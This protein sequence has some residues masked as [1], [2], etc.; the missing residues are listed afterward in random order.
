MSEDEKMILTLIEYL[1][2]KITLS[3]Q[4]FTDE[5]VDGTH[6]TVDNPEFTYKVTAK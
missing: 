4:G 2:L 5:P 3:G 6:F 1:G